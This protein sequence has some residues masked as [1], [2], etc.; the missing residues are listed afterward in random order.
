MITDAEFR[1]TPYVRGVLNYIDPAAP[2]AV[3]NDTE[4]EKVRMN[5]VAHEVEIHDARAV[6]DR[7]GLDSTGFALQRQRSDVRDFF[8]PREVE[9]CYLPETAEQ[10]RR[11]TGAVHVL[12]FGAAVRNAREAKPLHPPVLNVHIDYDEPT[13][14][15]KAADMLPTDQKHLLDGRIMLI[16]VWR[17]ISPVESMPLALCDARSV[18]AADPFP[19]QLQGSVSGLA[20]AAGYNVAHNPAHRWFYASAMRPDEVLAFRRCDTRPGAPQ[21]TAHTAFVDPTSAPDAPG[22]QSIEVRIIAFMGTS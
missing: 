4:R 14:R 7:L 2:E 16:N 22:R 13:V 1:A 5:L 11:L 10:V 3:M 6:Q 21:G 15:S 18:T 12:P 19:W 9:A 8:D 20:T 17:P